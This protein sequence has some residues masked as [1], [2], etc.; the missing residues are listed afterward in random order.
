MQLIDYLNIAEGS[1]VA[2]IGCGG[3]TSFIELLADR[4]RD[5]KTLVSTTTKMFPMKIDGIT[6]CETPEQ[7]VGH[8]PHT[9]VQCFGVLNPASG[10]L[11]ALPADVLAGLVPRYDIS[12]LEADGSRGLPCKGWLTEEPVVPDYCTHT[13][14]I[15]TMNALGKQAAENVVH[16]LPEFLTLT[17]LSAGDTITLQ[18]LETMVC[19]PRGMFHSSAGRLLLLVNQVEDDTT[20]H[21]AILFLQGIKEKY[22]NRYIKLLYGSV[23]LDSWQEV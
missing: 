13:V 7:C 16:R 10:K 9:G 6:S 1:V 18:T 21:T 8:E 17:G 12:L 3:K 2:V 19:G 14:G 4:L 5:K 15:V 20:A 11:E 22:P 23:H